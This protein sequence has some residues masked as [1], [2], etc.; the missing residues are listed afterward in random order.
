MHIQCSSDDFLKFI[1]KKL[2][3]KLSK[4]LIAAS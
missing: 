2:P 1:K 3:K 4:Q